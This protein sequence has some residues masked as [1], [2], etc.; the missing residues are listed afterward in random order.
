MSAAPRGRSSPAHHNASVTASPAGSPDRP[1]HQ[2]PQHNKRASV[3]ESPVESSIFAILENEH[4]W[5][6]ND[7]GQNAISGI[8]TDPVAA[9]KG[10]QKPLK[11]MDSLPSIPVTPIKKVR[12]SDFDPFVKSLAEVFDKYQYNRAIGVS[13][14]TEGTPTLA[15]FEER[16]SPSFTNLVELTNRLIVND[17]TS[18]RKK[19][20]GLTV[21]QRTRL[22]SAHAP[23]LET[24]PS[25]FFDPSFDLGNPTTFTQVCENA[26]FSKLTLADVN[27]TSSLLQDKLSLLQDTVDVHLVKEISRRATS[28]FSALSA[29]EA[30]HQETQS[31][32][33]Q[34]HALRGRL[35]KLSAV[36]VEKGLEVA[37]LNTRRA[38]VAKLTDGI[39]RIASIQQTRPV[40]ASLV[41]R[42]DYIGA[43]ELM[44]DAWRELKGLRAPGDD[45]T[46][47]AGETALDLQ[48][49]QG[50]EHLGVQLREIYGTTE[51]RIQEELVALLVGEVRAIV[52]SVD[53]SIGMSPRLV[54]LP[55]SRWIGNILKMRNGAVPTDD[56]VHSGKDAPF[57]EIT[58]HD[59]F[60]G[61][62]DRLTPLVF[63]LL[64][65]DK[66]GPALQV[67]KDSLIKEIK[68][69][70]KKCYPGFED[71]SHRSSS[72]DK[73][74]QRMMLSRQLKS[75]T[76]DS[77]FDLLIQVYSILLHI[78]QRAALINSSLKKVFVEA[79]QQN[80]SVGSITLS[81]ASVDKEEIRSSR[82]K[83]ASN[84][85]AAD[86]DDDDLGLFDSLPTPLVKARS[87]GSISTESLHN[88]DE[89]TSPSLQDSAFA[90]LA[91]EANEALQSASDLSNARC[92]KLFAVRSE[93]NAQL[94]AK[95]FYRL[96]GATREFIS[97]GETLCGHHGVGL[98][99]AMQS[100]ARAYLTHFHDER[101]KQLAIVVENEQWVKAPVPIDFQEMVDGLVAAG[102]IPAEA[103]QANGDGDQEQ[104]FSTA[105]D[106]DESPTEKQGADSPAQNSAGA[107]KM[108]NQLV[109][110]GH[111]FFVAGCVLLLSKT[112]TDYLQCL[113]NIPSL[114]T[115]VL[116]RILEI[117]KIFNSKICQLILGAGA[118]KSAGL[119][120]I[121]AGHIALAS[122][123]IGAMLAL[124]PHLRAAIECK[125]PPKQK[126]LL[127]DFDRLSKD[128]KD[129]Q[130]ELF[131]KL[132]A[133]MSERLSVQCKHLV[134]LNWDAL[135]SNDL[136]SDGSSSTHM[137]TLVK[138][139]TTLH[140]VLVKYL[141]NKTLRKV[142]ADV[143]REYNRKMEDELKKID[144]FTSSGKNRLL[145]DVQFL[146]TSLS[147]FEGIDGPGNHLEVVVNNI[148]I[149]DRRTYTATS[150]A[151][152]A[153]AG[154]AASPG[155]GSSSKPPATAAS[156]TPR[157][158]GT[159]PPHQPNSR[160]SSLVA[161]AAAAGVSPAAG[162]SV[163]SG[164]GS[165]AS[166]LGALSAL[167]G[168]G[169]GGGGGG[170]SGGGGG[171]SPVGK[172]GFGFG[173]KE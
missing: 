112:L 49:V 159:G 48:G 100:Q 115:E 43:L 136:V 140:R 97:G 5:T 87:D 165:A 129:H 50:I 44:D 117:L 161:A 42:G 146:L 51:M 10:T 110:D 157:N 164:G 90:Q 12:T 27:L 31:C 1:Q 109:V 166:G 4:M 118:T 8:I 172:K 69:L 111:R 6:V 107:V 53:R 63:A 162:A 149:K 36:G 127:S 84:V 128:Y 46:A 30:L 15:S 70:T 94:N 54:G 83:D 19:N 45:A 137:A 142:M 92:A 153:G 155:S 68:V 113:T 154:S 47:A 71:A 79:K 150:S 156:S 28:F 103:P 96:L 132:V 62:E 2:S 105:A 114:T 134:A 122:Q 3:T 148:R 20:S 23:P 72:P 108:G 167:G 14:A 120:N 170:G 93:Q 73:R 65:I 24:V 75:M 91:A 56:A 152:S 40:I 9:S 168:F 99:S 141:D 158:A 86:D 58:V 135:D 81:N 29:L 121:N 98:K 163:G 11:G 123:S 18:T 95:D 131:A 57:N 74:E 144:L 16:E 55:A 17:E 82:R 34:I 78:L 85:A 76:F 106:A 89:Q 7:I 60:D 102:H 64:K 151:A 130:T 61:F 38:N 126:V 139:T 52:E 25:V 35:G 80:I 143:F 125:L 119:K 59:A 13:A 37:R 77:F 66:L 138:E 124:I 169:L 104:E 33:D 21:S 88:S 67:Y 147:S 116:Q 171:T 160:T 101:S 26:D 22:L 133:I 145:I 41:E 32:V 39:S 173:K